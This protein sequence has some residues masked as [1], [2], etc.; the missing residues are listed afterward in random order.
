FELDDF[1]NDGYKDIL[2]TCGDNADY[3]HTALKNYHGVYIF[4]NDGKDNFTQ[5]Y[6]FPIH[7]C[8]KAIAK[9][10]DN[11]GDLDIAAISFFPDEKNQPQEAFVYLENKGNSYFG[12]HFQF[13]PYSIK[14]FNAGKWLTMDAGDIDGDG[15]EDIVLGN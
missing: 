2:Y 11:D 5:Q 7:G 3:S 8:Y 10:F 6:F 9:D 13:E 1:N 4:I 14:E 12:N 15:D